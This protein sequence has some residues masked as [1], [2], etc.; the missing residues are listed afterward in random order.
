MLI[1]EKEVEGK[2]GGKR[3]RKRMCKVKK[4]IKE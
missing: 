1:V 3:R 2:K 4:I